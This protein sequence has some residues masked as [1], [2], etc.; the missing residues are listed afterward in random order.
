MSIKATI[1]VSSVEEL[2]ALTEAKVIEVPKTIYK[3]R[4]KKIEIPKIVYKEFNP[5]DIAAKVN[6]ELAK[7]LKE[8]HHQ[9]KC[10][11]CGSSDIQEVAG[12][13]WDYPDPSGVASY[14]LKQKQCNTCTYSWYV[15]TSLNK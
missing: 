6:E 2:R 9:E 14:P 15:N 11:C 7:V 10:L 1:E 13:Q 5:K 4:I 3:E 8:N 12:I